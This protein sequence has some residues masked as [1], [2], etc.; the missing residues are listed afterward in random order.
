MHFYLFISLIN[1][2]N[3]DIIHLKT[4][5]CVA[6]SLRV[7]IVFV[8]GKPVRDQVW[9]HR[10]SHAEEEASTG[11]RVILRTCD[12]RKSFAVRYFYFFEIKSVVCMNIFTMMQESN[13]ILDSETKC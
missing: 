13:V 8:G 3:L 11:K 9:I 2:G 5:S 6:V 7:K 4:A 1:I 12:Q 10:D